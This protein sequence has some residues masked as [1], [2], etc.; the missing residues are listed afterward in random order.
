MTPAPVA[1]R[2]PA[3]SFADDPAVGRLLDLLSA[4][5]EQAYVVGGAVRNALIGRESGDIDIATTAEPRLV[6]A[7]AKAAGLRSIPTGIEHG[8]VTVLV[9]HRPFEVTT[10]R[11]DVETDGRRATVSFSRDIREDAER[12]DFTMNALYARAD[13]TVLDP[14]GG[15]PDLEARRVRF[16]GDART[17]IRE[18]YLRILRLFRFH[19]DYGE[20]PLDTEA[21][22]AAIA[23]RAGLERLSAERIRSEWLKL[24]AARRAAE[25]LPTVA[26]A[27]FA[28]RVLGGVA[29]LGPFAR[30][31]AGFPAAAP[32]VRLAAL[33]LHGVH[34][35]ERLRLRLRLSGAEAE[36]LERAGRVLDRWHGR[37]E[38]LDAAA[39]RR[40]VHAFGNAEACDA[41]AVALACDG[42][43]VGGRLAALAPGLDAPRPRSP[44]SGAQLIA[45]G[46][47]P[48][49]GMG[50]ILA[51]AEAVWRDEGFPDD[52]SRHQ[53]ILDAVLA[54]G[55][56]RTPPSTP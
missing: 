27:G 22:D 18:D 44:W 23:L 51:E 55:T 26:E 54:R 40:L 41:V 10:L 9:A 47:A 48:G 24:L 8:T 31:L 53:A 13:G 3:G 32:I 52:E 33:A 30:L 49:P 50:A 14:V 34:D 37:A 28:E 45:R 11:R 46:I 1:A 19:A 4:D 39:A 15:L 29:R 25:V 2:L 21:R 43:D 38:T 42:L 6:V 36:A 16:I 35:V 56:D 12:R 17:R 7:R 20:G 5:G